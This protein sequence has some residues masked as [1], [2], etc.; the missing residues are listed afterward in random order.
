MLA[1][2]A[3]SPQKTKGRLFNE[4][5]TPYRNEFQ[6]DKDRIIHS[7]TFRRLQYK[8]QVFINHEGDHYRNRLT[9]S[10]EVASI[11]R[12]IARDL[13]GSEDLAECIA[14]A[15]D[16]GHTPFGH[17]GEDALHECMEG[18]LGFDHNAHAVR[19]L[20]KLE[21]RYASY[22][23]LNL[24][25]EVIE[26]IAKHNGPLTGNIPI[27]IKEYDDEHKLD[28][29]Q[30][31]SLESQVASLSDDITYNCHDLEDGI[32]AKMFEIEEL[33][34]IGSLSSIVR[35][36]LNKFPNE[37]ESSHI[38][39]V[40]RELAH[41]LIEDLL[42]Q[43]KTNIALYNIK[44]SDDIR[45]LGRPLVDFSDEI[46]KCIHEIRGFLKEKVYNNHGVIL[47]R[48]KCKKVVAELFKMYFSN[49]ECMPPIWQKRSEGDEIKK[50]RAVADYIAGMTDRFAI[51]R[52]NSLSLKTNF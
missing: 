39:E 28:L 42:K 25:W 40:V 21:K 1:E 51:D 10:I 48:Y 19:L 47:V 50:A 36:V 16:L 20:T 9:H 35:D 46:K 38:F 12:S 32:R 37:E 7:N 3:T 49:P 5:P 17:A 2:Y 6:R 18:F 22:E 14:L 41:V 52:F 45:T 29:H 24:T 15:H 8:T 4:K 43:T 26:G 27:A 34:D 23:G 30:F 44:S 31:S 33:Q 13:G 11:A